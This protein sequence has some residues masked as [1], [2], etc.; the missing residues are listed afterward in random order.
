MCVCV[1]CWCYIPSGNFLLSVL[2]GM[3]CVAF[4]LLSFFVYEWVNA[5]MAICLYCL[6]YILSLSSN[7][8]CFTQSPNSPRHH[9]HHPVSPPTVNTT[10]LL[11]TVIRKIYSISFIYGCYCSNNA[12]INLHANNTKK[13]AAKLTTF[14]YLLK[15]NISTFFSHI[16]F[17]FTFLSI[18]GEN[19]INGENSVV[20]WSKL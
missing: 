5:Y 14:Y 18:F 10:L 4:P 17:Q 9:Y 8:N 1:V 6:L 3:E 2:Y 15:I 7:R 16:P 13:S 12:S 11:F 19:I 20:I